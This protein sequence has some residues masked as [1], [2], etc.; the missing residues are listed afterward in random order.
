MITLKCA[1]VLKATKMLADNS[2]DIIIADPPYNI[3]KDFGNNHFN[4]SLDDYLAW[5]KSYLKELMRVLKPDGVLY[6]YGF[7]E[8]LAHVS[9]LFPLNK[10]KWL[11]WAYK[12]KTVPGAKTWVRSH[13]SILCVF[14]DVVP[15]FNTDLVRVPYTAAYLKQVGKV[16]KGNLS[17][18]FGK[19]DSVF[20]ANALGALA[21]DVIEIPALAGGAGISERLSA[22]LDCKMLLT[23]KAKATHN[24]THKIITH[25]T[26]KPAKLTE[27]LINAYKPLN[28]KYNLFIPFAGSG[29]EVLVAA[30]DKFAEI[31][32]FELNP[33]YCELI[34]LKIR[35]NT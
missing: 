4:L 25:P 33:D 28:Q 9:V 16:G 31:T 27:I 11:V 12:N 26:Q 10:V 23:N 17:S 29:S 8:I 34:K 20:K 2:Q 6:I 7:S 19:Q 18:R 24:Q 5:T 15:N 32:A 1:D 21:R 3:N 30:K 14:K 13:E 22:C 35:Y